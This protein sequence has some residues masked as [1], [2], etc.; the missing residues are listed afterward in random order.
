MP[1][2]LLPFIDLL[3]EY[4]KVTNTPVTG[5]HQS[6]KKIDVDNIKSKIF[7]SYLNY[8]YGSGGPGGGVMHD[9]F[10]E[11]DEFERKFRD[12]YSGVASVIAREFF[13][14]FSKFDLLKN[15][16][17]EPIEELPFRLA[18]LKADGSE[19]KKRKS[20]RRKSKR[21]KSKKR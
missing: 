21:R 7:E 10:W 11:V 19:K 6:Q 13:V 15:E 8:D 9:F 16:L 14:H 1:I 5:D 3:T 17:R 12:D 18:R 4:F 20:K 2:E